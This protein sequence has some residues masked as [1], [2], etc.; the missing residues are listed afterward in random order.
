MRP[1]ML[2]PD[3]KPLS[4]CENE[5]RDLFRSIPINLVPIW[6]S[7]TT[8]SYR[9][10]SHRCSKHTVTYVCPNKYTATDGAHMVGPRVNKQRW[11]IPHM[12]AIYWPS[13]LA[14]QRLMSCLLGTHILHACVLP[15]HMFPSSVIGFSHLA[16]RRRAFCRSARVKYCVFAVSG[17]LST[18]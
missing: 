18:T 11:R 8:L 7:R 13:W 5:S 15:D 12:R 6:I 17:F 3:E 2:L 9:A 1:F 4:C 16:Q 10:L 14:G